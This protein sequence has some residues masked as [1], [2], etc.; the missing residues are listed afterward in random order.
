M[1][2]IAAVYVANRND[3]LGDKSF[4]VFL[5]CMGTAFAVGVVN[6]VVRRRHR[7]VDTSRQVGEL[8]VLLRDSAAFDEWWPG[9]RLA[10]APPAELR[11]EATAATGWSICGN[12][13]APCVKPTPPAWMP[14][15]LPTR[16]A[17][18][19]SMR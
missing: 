3:A 5:I 18:P 8:H 9:D 16:G 6:A 17:W 1:W 19:R 12:T 11:A 15:L 4:P 10:F 14:R 7:P 13:C 2:S